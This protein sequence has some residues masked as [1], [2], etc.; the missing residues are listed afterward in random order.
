MSEILR[1]FATETK[2]KQ[3]MDNNYFY[4]LESER[5]RFDD[6]FKKFIYELV[7]CSNSLDGFTLEEVNALI[8]RLTDNRVFQTEIVQALCNKIDEQMVKEDIK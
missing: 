6:A 4:I 7:W 3:V 5:D 1:Y 8:K 2:N